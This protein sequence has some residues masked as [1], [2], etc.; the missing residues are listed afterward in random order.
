MD[1]YHSI[2]DYFNLLKCNIHVFLFPFCSNDM[3][4]WCLMIGDWLVKWLGVCQ[5][6]S[7]SK[8]VEMAEPVNNAQS[9]I[10]IMLKVPSK[11]LNLPISPRIWLK[12]SLKLRILGLFWP[13]LRGSNLDLNTKLHPWYFYQAFLPPEHALYALSTVYE[14]TSWD[15]QLMKLHTRY[16]KHWAEDHMYQCIRIVVFSMEHGI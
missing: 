2:S 6:C 5:G 3:A 16:N 10:K 13:N 12:N 15:L 7:F 1:A 11:S 9:S 14:N 8:Q 4:T